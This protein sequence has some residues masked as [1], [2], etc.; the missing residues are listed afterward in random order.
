MRRGPN[1]IAN[2]WQHIQVK[3]VQ[4][5]LNYV[6]NHFSFLC[7]HVMKSLFFG[8]WIMT[9]AAYLILIRSM[10]AIRRLHDGGYQNLGWLA[11]GFNRSTD[12]DFPDVEGSTK[13]Q[14][15]TIGGVSYFFLQLLIL[16][17]AVGGKGSG[18]ST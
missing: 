7:G 15:A 10:M 14:Y 11:G 6:V 9:P 13:L 8:L 18:S 5:K 2:N 3:V 12:D 16:V 17:Q 1:S 4:H